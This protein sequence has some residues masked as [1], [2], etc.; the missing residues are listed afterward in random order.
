MAFGLGFE[1]REWKT[2]NGEGHYR[3]STVRKT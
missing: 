3:L 2:R 1:G